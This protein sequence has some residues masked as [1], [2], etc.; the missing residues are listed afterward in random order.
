MIL[1]WAYAANVLLDKNYK[2]VHKAEG[3]VFNG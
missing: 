3:G 2:I 1:L